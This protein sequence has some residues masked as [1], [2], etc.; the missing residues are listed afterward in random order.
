M[1]ICY[2]GNNYKYI[3][4]DADN[5]G[6][7]SCEN[8]ELLYDYIRRI[9]IIRKKDRDCFSVYEHFLAPMSEKGYFTLDEVVTMLMNLLTYKQNNVESIMFDKY[10]YYLS[11]TKRAIIIEPIYEKRDGIELFIPD[12]YYPEDRRMLRKRGIKK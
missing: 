9:Y 7:V 8:V 1:K 2:S 11:E 6:I 12:G 3:P 10:Y 4:D 5:Y